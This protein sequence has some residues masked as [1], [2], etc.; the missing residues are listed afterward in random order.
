MKVGEYYL[1]STNQHVKNEKLNACTNHDSIIVM[2]ANGNKA[3]KKK[4]TPICFIVAFVAG[5]LAHDI[6]Q[7]IV[8]SLPIFEDTKLPEKALV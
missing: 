5:R 8:N 1:S 6:L 2:V 4:K 7:S 3:K